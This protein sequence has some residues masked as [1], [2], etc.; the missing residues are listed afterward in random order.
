MTKYMILFDV[1]KVE[2]IK[3]CIVY[4]CLYDSCFKV[5]IFIFTLQ[6]FEY[7]M[8]LSLHTSK[9]KRKTE[10]KQNNYVYN[11][12]W[13]IYTKFEHKMCIINSSVDEQKMLKNVRNQRW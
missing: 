6:Q 10:H 1:S 3:T 8:C 5:V 12:I 4:V 7:Y 2:N 9:M 11:T 13:L